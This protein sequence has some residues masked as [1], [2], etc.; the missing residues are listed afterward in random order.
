MP[1]NVETAAYSNTP[2]WHRE[3]TVLDTDGNKGMTIEVALPASGLDWEVEKVPCYAYGEYETKT[4]EGVEI[5]I[6]AQGAERLLIPDRW[7]VKRMTDN[8]MFG[9]VG[10]TWQPTQNHEGFQVIDDVINAASGGTGHAWI[11]SAM[12]LDGG[13]KVCILV[14]IE[15]DWQIA[16]E[17]YMQYMLFV[18]GHDGRTS[19]TMATTNIR[20]VCTNTLA[21]A[22]AGNQ[23]VVRVRHTTKAAERI[24]SAVHMLEMR[25]QYNEQLAIQGEFLAEQDVKDG[26][27]E[28]FLKQLFPV[29][30][31]D[32]DSP[33]KTMAEERRDDVRQIFM[34][35]PNLKPI[36][37][38][39]WGLVQAAV[40]Y[41]DHQREFKSPESEIKNQFGLVA[42][43]TDLKDRAFKLVQQP[44]LEVATA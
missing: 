7:G 24:K 17:D 26:E 11:E 23:R 4:V 3:G 14:H 8:R 29:K 10:N 31:E 41:A 15:N 35:A 25:N 32:E 42:S 13:K 22:L 36:G 18:N 6:P 28:A 16:G 33:A 2:A 38:T 12:A 20:V 34:A 21:L 9:T 44:K 40:E 1:A 39:R 5:Q 30:D 19:V 37:G 43:G 27:V